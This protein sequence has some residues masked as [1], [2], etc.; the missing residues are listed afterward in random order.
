MSRLKRVASDFL[1]T[2]R[3][4]LNLL[5]ARGAKGETN[6]QRLAMAERALKGVIAERLTPTQRRYLMLYCYEKQTMA[7]I[8]ALCGV[9]K[10]TVSRTLARAIRTIEAHLRYYF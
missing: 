5:A 10:S 7:A 2:D 9:N 1:Y 6:A 3:G 4:A 8:A